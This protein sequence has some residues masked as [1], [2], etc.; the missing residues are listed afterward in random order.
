MEIVNSQVGGWSDDDWTLSDNSRTNLELQ[1]PYKMYKV[2]YGQ[3]PLGCYQGS[4][5]SL[6]SNTRKGDNGDRDWVW[7]PP[8]IVVRLN[9]TLKHPTTGEHYKFI[10]SYLVKPEDITQ[11]DEPTGNYG[12]K[13]P[14][15]F[16][17]LDFVFELLPII[18]GNGW[19]N[20]F[21]N[22]SGA[23]DFLIFENEEIGPGRIEA[24]DKIIIKDNVSI[25]TGTELFA[26][27]SIE[28][29]SENTVY[30]E[31]SMKIGRSVDTEEC[32]SMPVDNFIA[33]DLSSFCNT[34]VPNYNPVL[35]K[36]DF[37]IDEKVESRNNLYSFNLYPNPTDDVVNI[38]VDLV[39]MAT[40]T[41]E[42][43]DLS[44][45]AIYN[46][47]T[48]SRE[49]NDNTWSINTSSFESG[50]YFVNVRQGANTMTKRLVITR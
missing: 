37:I 30:P 41:I 7:E 34:S 9:I 20:E 40:Y 2:S 48:S 14:T 45:R 5:F 16:E 11:S 18:G 10:H 44:G 15:C 39:D 46:R 17:C 50:I 23:A 21:T 19:A 28:I 6:I 13:A 22:S 33:T 4:K 38:E 43:L 29:R 27:S 35:P 24:W 26:G 36:K 49:F 25:L 42:V 3:M 12:I 1:D 47:T 8:K 31:V 32:A